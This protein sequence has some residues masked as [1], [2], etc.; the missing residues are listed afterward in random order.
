MKSGLISSGRRAFTLA[1]VVVSLAIATTVMAGIIVGYTVATRR[2]LYSAYSA[3]AQAM[4]TSRLE[5]TL[6]RRWLPEYGIDQLDVTNFRAGTPWETNYLALP[7]RQTN[8]VS[9]TNYVEVRD[10][11]SNPPLKMIRV[12]CAWSFQ[13]KV[14]TNTVATMRAPSL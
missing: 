10:I 7:V 13:N 9:A 8:L 1:E 3:A 12:D 14:Y 2:A 6:A 5:Q 11:G 4:A